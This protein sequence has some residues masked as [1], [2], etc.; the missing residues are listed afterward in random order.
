MLV[1]GT[2]IESYPGRMP[3]YLNGRIKEQQL[4]DI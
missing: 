1:V 2:L 4:V 3:E